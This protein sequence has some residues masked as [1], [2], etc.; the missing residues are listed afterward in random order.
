MQ[1][2]QLIWMCDWTSESLSNT[3]DH[4][5]STNPLAAV[6]FDDKHRYVVILTGYIGRKEGEG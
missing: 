2:S 3:T 6:S 4:F 1:S 5:F